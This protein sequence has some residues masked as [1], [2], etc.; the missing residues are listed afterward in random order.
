MKAVSGPTSA[1]FAGEFDCA[2]TYE[3]QIITMNKRVKSSERRITVECWAI[4]APEPLNQQRLENGLFV[5][6]ELAEKPVGDNTTSRALR[7][8]K[9]M[10]V[11]SAIQG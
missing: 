2:K 10:R 11:V 9:Q 1:G 7:F 3:R 4:L 5:H 8:P 6:W